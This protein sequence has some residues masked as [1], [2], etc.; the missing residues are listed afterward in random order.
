MAYSL[1][2]M[3]SLLRQAGWPENLIVTMAAIGMAESSGR[4]CIIGTIAPGE[5]SVGLFQINI[6]SGLKRPYTKE[7]L[8]DPLFNAKVALQLYSDGRGFRHWGAYTDGRYKQYI[9][10]SQAVYSPNATP[11]P[12]TQVTTNSNGAAIDTYRDSAIALPGN[13]T[14]K[15][16]VGIAVGASLLWLYSRS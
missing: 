11:T 3:Q 5:Y 12:V 6:G 9:A 10:Q 2:Q 14:T 8:C 15:T 16:L 1:A 13:L 4:E 7:Q